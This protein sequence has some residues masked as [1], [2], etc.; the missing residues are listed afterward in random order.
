MK[1]YTKPEIMFE[2]FSL[3]TSIA[4]GC[5]YIANHGDGTCGISVEIYPG[6][7]STVFNTGMSG[8]TY[9]P[10]GDDDSYNGI[11]YHVPVDTNNVFS[12]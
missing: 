10:P 8:C 3:S 11:C 2:D 12:S 4:T 6:Y 1:A 9:Q 5:E 7:S